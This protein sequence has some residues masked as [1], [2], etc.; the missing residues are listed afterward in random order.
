MS[1]S[2]FFVVELE[3]QSGQVD[4]LRS[5]ME[6]MVRVTQADEPGTLNYEW[7]LVADGSACHIFERYAD[8]AAAVVHSQT[9]PPELGERAQAFRPTRLTAYG[10]LT[11]EIRR[12]RIAPLLAAVPELELV[13]VDPLGGFTR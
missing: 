2:I 12:E 5:V 13:V 1:D 7:F 10:T 6:E 8:S 3:V 9:F 11:D 4:E